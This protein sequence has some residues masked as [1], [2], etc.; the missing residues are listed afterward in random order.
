VQHD[1]LVHVELKIA[2][3]TCKRRGVVIAEYLHCDHRQCFTLRRVDFS[4]HD[5]KA[6]VVFRNFEFANSGT[7][8]TG[9]PTNVVSYLHQRPSKGAQSATHAHPAVVHR[10]CREFIGSRDERLAG[11]LGDPL[12]SCFTIPVNLREIGAPAPDPAAYRKSKL[13]AFD[14]DVRFSEAALRAEFSDQAVFSRTF[15]AVVGTSL[16]QRRR[17]ARH[18]EGQLSYRLSE[19]DTYRRVVLKIQETA[20][21]RNCDCMSAVVCIELGKDVLEVILD[22]VL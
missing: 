5:G 22:G 9:V 18:R 11:F 16:G 7:R 3:R 17:E 1:G 19:G 8:V 14:L 10:E 13:A 2:L 4:W 21:Q 20:L 12:G 6:Q 15:R